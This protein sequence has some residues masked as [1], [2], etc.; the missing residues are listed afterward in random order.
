MLADDTQDFGRRIDLLIRLFAVNLV[1]GK[2]QREQIR[3]L[4]MAG[5]GPKEI[6]ALLGTTPNTVNVALTALR[7]KGALKLNSEGGKDDIAR[8][9]RV[10]WE[11]VARAPINFAE[12]ARFRFSSWDVVEGGFFQCRNRWIDRCD[13]QRSRVKEISTKEKGAKMRRVDLPAELG[14]AFKSLVFQMHIAN[15]TQDEI[16]AYVGKSKSTINEMLKPLKKRRE[17]RSGK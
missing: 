6:A 7:K 13:S 5:M 10:A 16:A 2:S 4:A 3:L 17:D 1:N 14:L 12:G 15:Y 11:G 9:E 8:R